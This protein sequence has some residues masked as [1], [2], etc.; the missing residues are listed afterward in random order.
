MAMLKG[1]FLI[2]FSEEGV[3]PATLFN[4]MKIFLIA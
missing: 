1:E 3:E 4:L 2:D